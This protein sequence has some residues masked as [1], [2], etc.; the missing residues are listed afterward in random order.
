[1]K[2]FS[3]RR[4]RSLFV[5]LTLALASGLVSQGVALAQPS[6]LP[7]QVFVAE[8]QYT[9]EGGM[10]APA[11]IYKPH[12]TANAP[13]WWVSSNEREG[14]AGITIFDSETNNV[15]S[16][17]NIDGADIPVVQP[18]G[19]VGGAAPPPTEG[20]RHPH[21]IALDVG[22][23]RAYQVI[24]HSGLQWNQDRTAFLPAPHSDE[25]SGLLVEYDVSNPSSPQLVKGWVLGHASEEDVVNT[26]NGKVYVG[27][28]EPSTLLEDNGTVVPINTP[29]FVSVIKPDEQNSY[30]FIDLPSSND[31]VQGVGY[32]QSLNTING[33]THFGQKMFTFNSADDTIAYSVDIRGPF[34]SFIAGLPADQQFT[35]EPGWIV[36][37]H[38]LT[39]DGTNHV[40]Y[41]TIHTLGTPQEVE[42]AEASATE[43][44]TPATTTAESSTT[45]ET[46]EVT[47][48]WVAAVNTNPDSPNFQQVTIIDLSNGQSVPAFRNHHDAVATG[49]PYSQLFVHA[50]FLA[51]DPARHTLFVS[52]EH[53]GNLGMVNT[54]DNKLLQVMTIP[55]PIPGST[56]TQEIEPHV[57]GVSIAPS[58]GVA[59]VSDEAVPG[60]YESITLAPPVTGPTLMVANPSPGD[61]ITPGSLVMQGVAFDQFATDGTGVD[62]VSVFLGGRESG[63]TFLGDAMLGLP[64]FMDPGARAQF[65]NAG[66]RLTT[67]ALQ[68]SGNGET[69]FVYA[70]SSVTGIETVT[71]I[72]VVIGS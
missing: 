16:T 5:A 53:T 36:H 55:L 58:T 52:G 39:T 61:T 24:E 45:T 60:Q 9:G 31:C 2:A 54:L 33:T 47:G 38:D 4:H 40:A 23:G 20:A 62:R 1:M 21:G 43:D 30:G 71:Q 67:P 44:E 56:P 13:T 41:Q 15:L 49:L 50:H 72:P 12:E 8:D 37:L 65:D 22:R 3:S 69:L 25:E 68:G 19:S 63:G 17:L 6:Y 14:Q 48:R 66:W 59:Y 46:P 10:I 26:E 70:R 57:H 27:N 51:V 34:D 64:N 11:P 29:C 32:D 35:M 28:H 18:D 42:A 7:A